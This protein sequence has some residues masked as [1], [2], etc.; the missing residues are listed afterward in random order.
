MKIVSYINDSTIEC[1]P[2]TWGL[3]LFSFGCN[4]HCKMCEGYNYEIVTNKDN[5]TNDAISVI[6]N[7][8]TPLHDCVVF[9]GGE[10]TIWGDNLIKALKFCK[11]KGLHT[12][13]FTNGMLPDVVNE[14]NEMKLCDAWSVDYKGIHN[15]KENFGINDLDYTLNVNK[16]LVNIMAYRL[17]LEIRTTFFEGNEADREDI[18]NSK[19]ELIERYK[20]KN[21][22]IYAK[23]IPQE[24]IRVLRNGG[25][26]G[27]C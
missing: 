23:F 10:P 25:N 12:K 13:I 8:I 6:K 9:L 5:I 26:N 4:L 21:D 7:N 14:I 24:D 16:T 17:P 15:I 27:N 18:T 1:A 20:E 3:T 19:T 2:F 22:G 11:D